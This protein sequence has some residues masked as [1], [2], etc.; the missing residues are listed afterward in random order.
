[1]C[2][3]AHKLRMAI[4]IYCSEWWVNTAREPEIPVSGSI[5]KSVIFQ[6]KG[7]RKPYEIQDSYIQTD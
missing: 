5:C 4:R 3:V 6:L 2:S 7:K 1:M